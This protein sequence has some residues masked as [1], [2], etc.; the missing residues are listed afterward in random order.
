MKQV[1]FWSINSSQTRSNERKGAG[2]KAKAKSHLIMIHCILKNYISEVV[3]CIN[4]LVVANCKSWHD[5][6]IPES[7]GLKATWLFS[8]IIYI[9][10]REHIKAEK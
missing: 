10:K 1:S 8:V 5:N 9:I 4:C 7:G 6:S 2:A 3:T